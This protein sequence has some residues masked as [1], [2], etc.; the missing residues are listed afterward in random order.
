MS[1]PRHAR[2]ASCPT[3][4]LPDESRTC[5]PVFMSIPSCPSPSTIRSPRGI[6]A[7]RGRRARVPSCASHQVLR[8]RAAGRRGQL[9]KPERSRFEDPSACS[10]IGSHFRVPCTP[11]ITGGGIRALG[12][13]CCCA[14]RNNYGAFL[15]VLPHAAGSAHFKPAPRPVL[16]ISPCP[17]QA[18]GQRGWYCKTPAR[19]CLLTTSPS[20]SLRVPSPSLPPR[21]SDGPPSLPFPPPPTPAAII[22]SIESQLFVI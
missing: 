8:A 9:V 6:P 7:S 18:A 14:R 20:P 19:R 12:M 16:R 17:L 2:A 1:L 10:R 15:Q 5:P 13:R 22:A 11:C 3:P 21:A 4:R